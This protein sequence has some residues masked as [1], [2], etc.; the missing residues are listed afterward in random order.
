MVAITGVMGYY[1]TTVTMSYDFTSAIPANNAKYKEYK[2]FQHLFGGDDG[3]TIVL[4]IETPN[5]YTL[6]VFNSYAHFIQQCKKLYAV[7]NILSVPQSI[8][9]SKDSVSEKLVAQSIFPDN[10]TNQ[11]TLDS[12]KA[13]FE[14]LPFYIERLYHGHTYLMA[15]KVN[16]AIVNSSRRVSFVDSLLQLTKAFEKQTN[17]TIH[18]SG[19]PLIRTLVAQKLTKET[20]LFLITSLVLSALT[21]FLFFRSIRITLMSLVVVL[22]GVLWS[23]GLMGILG[24]KINTLTALVPPLIVVIGIPNCIYFLNKYHTS[25]QLTKNKYEALIAMID[26]M[27]VVTLFCN[28]TAAIGFGVFAFTQSVV[29]REF[30]VISGV[31]IIVLFLISLLCIPI[32]LSFMP[33]PKLRHTKYL[34]NALLHKVL[35]RIEVWSLQHKKSVIAITVILALVSVVGMLRLKSNGYIVDDLPKNDKVYADLKFFEKNFRGIM[36][37]EI[38]IDTKKKN[39]LIRSLHTLEKIDTLSAYIASM[40]EMNRPLS[41]VEGLKFAKQAYYN[42]DSSNYRIPNEFDMAFLAPYLKSKK[43]ASSTKQANSLSVILASF[44]DSNRQ[45]ARLSVS[46]ADVGSSKLPSILDSIKIKSHVIFDTSYNISLTGASVTFLEGTTFIING[47]TQSALWAFIFI[48][49]CMIYL[50]KSFK[51]VLCSL[52]PNVVPLIITAGVMG[53]AGIPLKPSTV[54]IFSVALGIAIDITIR[55]LVNYKQQLPRYAYKA[56]PTVIDTIHQTGISILYTSLVLTIGFVVFCMSSFGSIFALGWLTSF[57]L[58]VATFT[59]VVL[60]PVLLLALSKRNKK[61]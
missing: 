52:I 53:W 8:F 3:N 19:L 22:V 51:I 37:L 5:F 47:L 36:P 25:Y 38:L 27:G 21:L 12:C 40:P 10:I 34:N 50:F 46:M 61:Q 45:I 24:Y 56:R 14:N 48:A 1:A 32:V 43:N 11:H 4:G 39:G 55:F 28:I 58:I 30:G 23:T 31:G 20:Q 29:L 7:E 13:I 9:L 18:A 41:L 60:L 59:N 26:R 17:I 16:K 35:Q 33:V 49:V 15:I 6:P 2:A 54:L 57:T 42:G 44:I